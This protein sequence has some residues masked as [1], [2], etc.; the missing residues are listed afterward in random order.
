MT[1]NDTLKQEA[2]LHYTRTTDL[3][4][5]HQHSQR[6]VDVANCLIHP[7]TEI[8]VVEFADFLFLFLAYGV[9]T[10]KNGWVYLCARSQVGLHTR[11]ALI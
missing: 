11:S 2:L 8:P 1:P 7:V 5:L 9:L 4:W 6:P 10:Y 3:S